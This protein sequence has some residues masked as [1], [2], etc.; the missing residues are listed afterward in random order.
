MYKKLLEFT[1]KNAA[2]IFFA[3]AFVLSAASFLF[4]GDRVVSDGNGH[5]ANGDKLSARAVLHNDFQGGPDKRVYVENTGETPLYVRISL[6]EYMELDGKSVNTASKTNLSTWVEHRCHRSA[7]NCGQIF[8][9]YFK[10][11]MGGAGEFLPSEPDTDGTVNRYVFDPATATF[12]DMWADAELTEIAACKV[13]TMEA[14]RK[15][16]QAARE[17]FAGWVVDSDGFAYWTQ[18]VESGGT[19]GLL[20][21]QIE[22]VK[23]PES[24]YYYA[25]NTV[26]ETVSSDDLGAWITGGAMKN[27]E[28]AAKASDNAALYVLK[29]L[30][31]EYELVTEALLE[32]NPQAAIYDTDQD[33]FL[34]A[35]EKEKMGTLFVEEY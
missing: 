34:S 16:G 17:V 11:K 21:S 20:I 31:P 33:G 23:D 32:V 28:T 30:S 35:D 19:T 27:G 1:R 13:V 15:M 7:A 22:L 6:T 24:E 2:A 9:E 3:V 18:G 10:W 29:P 14:F 5:G 8:H 25:V 12:V 4:Y 26:A